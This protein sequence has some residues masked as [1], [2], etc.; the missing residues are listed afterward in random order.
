MSEK[1]PTPPETD[2]RTNTV[3]IAPDTGLSGHRLTNFYIT[4]ILHG[5]VWMVFHFAVVYFF[6]LLLDSVA[7]V[8]IFL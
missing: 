6:G 3:I 8:G 1:Q 7:L 4:N 2:S 5:V